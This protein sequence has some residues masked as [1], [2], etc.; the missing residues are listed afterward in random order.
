M[1]DCIGPRSV[2]LC[3]PLAAMDRRTEP[4]RFLDA[5]LTKKTAF[6][7]AGFESHS[8]RRTRIG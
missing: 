2:C 5:L 8:T 4:Q 6:R 7:L 1:I 3:M